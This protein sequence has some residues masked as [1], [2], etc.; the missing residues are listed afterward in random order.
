[1]AV[2]QNGIEPQA[3]SPPREEEYDL[4]D[5]FRLLRRRRGVVIGTVLVLTTAAALISS[6]LTPRYTAVST[7]VIEPRGARIVNFNDGAPQDLPQDNSMINTHV[8]LLTANSFI[9]RVIDKLDLMDDPEFNIALQ[10]KKTPGHLDMLIAGVSSWLKAP[11]VAAGLANDS[12]SDMP[13]RPRSDGEG[14]GN[15]PDAGTAQLDRSGHGPEAGGIP[16]RNAV[17]HPAELVPDDEL[18]I[19]RAAREE[20]E[21]ADGSATVGAATP[22]RAEERGPPPKTGNGVPDALLAAATRTFLGQLAV[23]ASGQ[24]YAVS[25]AFTSV[26]PGTAARVANTM[27]ELYVEHQLESK[28]ATTTGSLDWL[29]D[30][31]TELRRQLVQADQAAEAYRAENGLLT[32]GRGGIVLGEQ[33][34]A[35][36]NQE[37]IKARAE[38]VETEA[39][40]GRIRELLSSGASLESAPEVMA[41][42]VIANLRQQQTEL[43]REEAQ[44]R[45]EYGPRHPSI[46]QLQAERD[47]LAARINAEIRNIIGGLENQIATIRVRERTLEANLGQAKLGA[48][49]TS[50]AE[51]QLRLL[52]REAESTRAL[53]ET[54]LDRFKQLTEQREMLDPGVRVISAA[55]IPA[56]PSFPQVKLMTGAAFMGSLMFAMLLAFIVD[57]LDG[58]LRTGRQAE[59]VLKIPHI[60]FI[61]KVRRLSRLSPQRYLAER[62]AS[63]Y[64]EAIR[65]VQTALYFSN[66]DQPPQIVLVTSSLPAEGK[67]TF[68]LSLAVLLAR[69]GC[70]TVAVDLDFRRP[71]LGRDLKETEGGDLID[72]ILGE[73]PLDEVLHKDDEVDDLDILPVK[74]LTASPTD[75]LASRKMASLIAELRGRYDYVIL[76]SPPLLGISDSRFAALLA[77]AV[78][79]VVRWGKTGDELALKAL[80]ILRESGASIAGAVLT[81]VNVRRHRKYGPEDVV[82]Y[83]G[84]YK[85]Y[86]VK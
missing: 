81:Q 82:H 52:E 25:I 70:K 73:K 68:A 44:L 66:I 28:R 17:A 8:K 12:A 48:G 27:A 80:G 26:D 43:L 45:Q 50:R 13:D 56:E 55:A 77:D 5:V 39:K 42:S 10:D 20:D 16:V 9:H 63:V 51:I 60:G 71:T 32:S 58:G 47:N 57:R 62:P 29:N 75:L 54:F 74:R 2:R 18:G 31:L 4:R 65:T 49:Q 11:L 76:D 78:V 35:A 34:L 3:K 41:S 61:P 14:G 86:Y 46:I 40:L 85:K 79:F 33:E 1:M 22:S 83:Y 64:A 24:S 69:S 38:R 6:N 84:K 19:E 37:L 7:V 30:R 72:F 23:G 67:T 21:G 15:R 59:E 53:Y 36:L